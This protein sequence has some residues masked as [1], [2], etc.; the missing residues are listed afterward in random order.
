MHSQRHPLAAA[1]GVLLCVAAANPSQAQEAP[2]QS[3]AEQAKTMDTVTVTGSHIKRAQISGVGPVTVVDAETIERSGAT[4]IETLLQRL[5]ASAGFAG[6]QTNAYWANNGYGFGIRVL[7]ERAAWLGVQAQLHERAVGGGELVDGE[8]RVLLRVGLADGLLA[9]LHVHD[10]RPVLVVLLQAVHATPDADLRLGLRD[11]HVEV[12]LDRD[13]R[14]L[15]PGGR[16]PGEE[17]VQHGV[18][19]RAFPTGEPRRARVDRVDHLA[20]VRAQ[21]VEGRERYPIRIRYQRDLRERI[22]DL[23][24][25]PVVTESA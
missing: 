13:L 4:T 20:V 18:D 3:T 9:G 5:P 2:T 8:L 7:A 14:Q 24:R 22:D 1:I 25:L 23:S 10:D 6:S 15:A 17:R 16:D 21:T 19:P 12:L 11:L